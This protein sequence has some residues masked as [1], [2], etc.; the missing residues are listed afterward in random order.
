MIETTR[1]LGFP[2]L[3]CNLDLRNYDGGLTV[4]R[5]FFFSDSGV[6]VCPLSHMYMIGVRIFRAHTP[7]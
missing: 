3:A 5:D 1:N 2:R 7:L 6:H 4:C